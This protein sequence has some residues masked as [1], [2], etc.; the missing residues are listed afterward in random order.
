MNSHS[1]H[2]ALWLGF[3]DGCGLQLMSGSEAQTRRGLQQLRG[4]RFKIYI[5]SGYFRA[6]GA[7]RN[8][9]FLGGGGRRGME[10]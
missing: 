8:K 3:L 1:H 5:I 10:F 2:L 7:S 6:N 4:G 9:T